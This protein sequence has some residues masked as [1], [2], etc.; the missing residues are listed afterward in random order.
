M[1]LFHPILI[2]MLI[3][4]KFS[5][6]IREAKRHIY[7]ASNFVIPVLEKVLNSLCYKI[8]NSFESCFIIFSKDF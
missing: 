4:F 6:G 7:N 2:K 8:S 5:V 1:E 3:R